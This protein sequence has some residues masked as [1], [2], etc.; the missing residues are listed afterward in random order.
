MFNLLFLTAFS[1]GAQHKGKL[2]ILHTNDL[3]SRL[4][5][6][7]PETQY[8]PLTTGDDNTIGGFAR[9]ASVIQAEREAAG[10]NIL[11]F[12]AGDFLMGT[13]F[14]H[15]E[16]ED[17]FQLRLMKMMGYDAIAV[18]NHEFDAGPGSLASIVRAGRQNGEIPPVILS[19]AVFSSG[20]AADDPL[21][22]LYNDGTIV[23]ELIIE[24]PE[25]GLKIGIFSLLGVNAADVAPAASPVTFAK[26]VKTAG[27]M[28][29]HLRSRGCNMIICLSHSGLSPD[30]KG[31]LAGEDYEL[32]LKVKGIDLIIS[33]HTHTRLT[34]PLIVNGVP[35]V[36][37]G[38]YGSGIGRV[39]FDI[40]GPKPVMESYSLIPV[41]D[42]I[43]GD[44]KVVG[45]IEDRIR[46]IDGRILSGMGLSYGGV[47]AETSFL[48]EC[49]QSGDLHSSNLGPLVAD[50]IHA[51][52]N[53]YSDRG[54]DI[55]IVAAGVIRDN[56]VPG[57]QSVPDMFR[58]MSLGEG[59]DGMPGYPLARV[60]VTG[61]ELKNVLEI[62]LVAYKSSADNFIYYSGIRIYYDPSKGM[63]RKIQSAEL[64][65]GDGTVQGI[66]FSKKNNTLYSI[67]A[68]SYILEFVGII[69]KMS[70]GLINVVPR[71]E[72]GNPLADFSRAVINFSDEEGKYFEGKE[73]IALLGYISAMADTNGNGIP[74]ISAGYIKPER[75]VI[76]VK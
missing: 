32:A 47:V 7:A 23:R 21:E 57:K 18:G 42:K 38:A 39:V 30:K 60:F 41:D 12:D 29:K 55:S 19:N 3:H 45:M 13:L 72:Q 35:I 58:V 34:E 59:K 76:A 53:R 43:A 14:H 37:T 40:A 49:D 69:K 71:D 64:V 9:I 28:V 61:R 20:E 46:M 44:R 73:W 24:K 68:N 62:L 27:E 4:M 50:A 11:V 17:G 16:K 8:S 26:Q 25:A 70:F 52:V 15:F 51:Y 75:N 65:R 2:V 10:D 56:I 54:S 74:E 33:G 36:Q 5:G 31:N 67:T 22:E 6:A 1:I 63:L 66:D 48:L